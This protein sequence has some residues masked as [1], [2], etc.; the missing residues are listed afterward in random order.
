M[1]TAQRRFM[2]TDA[3]M[4]GRDGPFSAKPHLQDRVDRPFPALWAPHSVWLSCDATLAVTYGVVRSRRL[5]GRFARFVTVWR[6]ADGEY[7]WEVEFAGPLGVPDVPDPDPVPRHL[8]DCGS[9][10]P[11]ESGAAKLSAGLLEGASNDGTLTYIVELLATGERRF[12]ASFAE[13]EGYVQVVE[14]SSDRFVEN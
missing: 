12:Q 6:L 3:Y 5:P 2:A 14:L 7:R 8:P 13:G 4:V 10:Q 1:W 9:A 11:V